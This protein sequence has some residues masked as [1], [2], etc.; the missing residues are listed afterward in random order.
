MDGNKSAP[1]LQRHTVFAASDGGWS[2]V[3]DP[4]V[5]SASPYEIMVQSGQ[6]YSV[7]LSDVLFGE[8]W[9]CGGQSNMELTVA[10]AFNASEELKRAANFPLVRLVHLKNTPPLSNIVL[11][12]AVYM[13]MHLHTHTRTHIYIFRLM[14]AHP[15]CLRSCRTMPCMPA[16]GSYSAVVWS[17]QVHV[18]FRCFNYYVLC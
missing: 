11:A 15:A 7:T 8:L 16:A 13:Q 17:P 4:V 3:L 1:V 5:A 18:C 12:Y 6:L 10:Q 14:Y 9:M 2:A